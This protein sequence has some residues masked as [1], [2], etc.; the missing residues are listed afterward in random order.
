MFDAL[1]DREY[2]NITGLCQASGS[3]K[4]LQADERAARTVRTDKDPIDKIGTRQMKRLLRNRFALV[5]QQT[6]NAA[7][8]GATEP[9][10]AFRSIFEPNCL[11]IVPASAFAGSVAPMTLRSFSIAF[12]D[13]RTIATMGPSVMNFTRAPKNGRSLWT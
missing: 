6:S 2:R 8:S 5:R 4:L 3:E 1:I 13:S 11:R 7:V 12:S 10:I 9:W